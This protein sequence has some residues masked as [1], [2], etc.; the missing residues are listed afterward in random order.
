MRHGEQQ[1]NTK[2]RTGEASPKEGRSIVGNGATPSFKM[3]LQ[4]SWSKDR[5]SV[6]TIRG[7]L[8]STRSKKSMNEISR[9]IP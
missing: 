1:K 5:R 3:M 8:I 7:I 6:W 2:N 4:S 9:I